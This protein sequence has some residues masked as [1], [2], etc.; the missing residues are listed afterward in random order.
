LLR[1]LLSAADKVKERRTTR[2]PLERERE[3]E[4]ETGRKKKRA[5]TAV[6]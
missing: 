4:K 6:M 1:N 5:S 3:R 2:G